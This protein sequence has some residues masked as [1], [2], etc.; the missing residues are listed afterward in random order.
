MKHVNNIVYLTWVNEIANE[1]WN[2]LTCRAIRNKYYWIVLKHEIN[3]FAPA[4]LK[5][6]LTVKTLVGENNASK[7]IRHTQIFNDE[8]IVITAKSTWCLLNSTTLKPQM[9]PK[10][11]LNLFV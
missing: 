6:Q 5:N 1:H 10:E 3:Y 4:F 7:S 9:I 11:I 8:T 2:Q